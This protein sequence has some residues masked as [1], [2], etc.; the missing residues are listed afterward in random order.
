MQPCEIIIKSIYK[1]LTIVC[2]HAKRNN[3]I[4]QNPYIYDIE[5][6]NSGQMKSK[7]LDNFFRKVSFS[8]VSS[9][10]YIHLCFAPS[11]L[12][13]IENQKRV[14]TLTFHFTIQALLALL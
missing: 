13:L 5:R 1:Q 3:M 11:I 12:Y 7:H 4:S 6:Y 14:A 10:Y 8:W 9:V 2:P